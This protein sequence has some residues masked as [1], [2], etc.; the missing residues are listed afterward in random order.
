MHKEVEIEQVEKEM[1]LLKLSN[2]KIH[3]NFFEFNKNDKIFNLADKAKGKVKLQECNSCRN[4]RFEKEKDM[5]F[6]EF[7][8]RANCK[9]CCEKTRCYP[10]A[11]P[12]KKGE[13]KRGTICV[14]CDR[15]FLV[16]DML[17]DAHKE[18]A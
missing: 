6:C 17:E 15:K 4:Q 3:R 13:V 2:F 14:L 7:C 1:D 16:R 9:N 10:K 12:N 5:H 8:T 18:I 11:I